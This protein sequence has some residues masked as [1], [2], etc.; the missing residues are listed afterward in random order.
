MQLNEHTAT[1]KIVFPHSL[2]YLVTLAD[3]MQIIRVAENHALKLSNVECFLF[4]NSPYS[5]EIACATPELLA[6]TNRHKLVGIEARSLYARGCDT[7][8]QCEILLELPD[9]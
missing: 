7:F 2:E 4:H 3:C 6:S 9:L 8:K 1:R 5:L